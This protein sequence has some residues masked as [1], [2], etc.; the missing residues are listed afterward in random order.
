[1]KTETEKVY[2]AAHGHKTHTLTEPGLE[3]RSFWSNIY[4]L[5]LYVILALKHCVVEEYWV[6][7]ENT[8]D[9]IVIKKSYKMRYPNSINKMCVYVLYRKGEKGRID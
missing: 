2:V 7:L 5:N 9:V 3:P 6:T 8:F 1:M 4:V